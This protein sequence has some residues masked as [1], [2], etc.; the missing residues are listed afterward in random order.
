[1]MLLVFHD[2]EGVKDK[3]VW[4]WSLQTPRCFERFDM[5][6]PMSVQS[7]LIV[8]EKCASVSAHLS[9]DDVVLNR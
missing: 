6:L 7:G 4:H 1:M 8:A 9:G 3:G 5:S 2:A